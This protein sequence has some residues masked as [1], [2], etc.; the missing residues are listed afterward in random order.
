MVAL[1]FA[2]KLDPADVKIEGALDY[3]QSSD[4]IDYSGNPPFSAFVFSAKG[5]DKI[6]VNVKGSDRKATVAIAD[7]GLNELTSG[8]THIA[9]QVPDNGPDAEA[10]YIVFRDVEGKPAKLTVEL[11]RVGQAPASHAELNPTPELR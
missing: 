7:G 4:P 10:Y 9:F 2:A 5:G 1:L 11:K 6:E 3:G 8:T